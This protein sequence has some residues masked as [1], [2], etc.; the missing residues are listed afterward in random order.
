MSLVYLNGKYKPLAET[1]VNVLDRGFTFGDGVYEVV[2]VFNRKIFQFEAHLNRLDH[3][4]KSIYLDNPLARETWKDIFQRLINAI[5]VSDQSLYLQITRGVSPRDHDISLADHPTVFVMSRPM[6]ERKLSGG[7]SAITHAD[8]RWQYCDV[9]ATSLLASVLLRHKAGEH[10]A[11]EAILVRDGK[12]TE[13]AASNVFLCR[14]GQVLTPEKCNHVLP[15][16]TR[17]LLLEIFR[18]NKIDCAERSI[19]AVELSYA[20]EIWISSSTWEIV[21]V[22]RLDDKPVGKGRPGA[23]WE[24]V[25]T[26]YQKFKQSFCET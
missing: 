11:R 17:D 5:E 6:P 1:S 2:P 15:G 10:G 25:N 4:L 23:V 14:D 13:G 8:I 12:V 26:L 7:I 18:E 21:P 24:R 9:K 22:I 3:S 19:D 20:D 16:I